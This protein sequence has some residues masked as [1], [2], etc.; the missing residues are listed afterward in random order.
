M[1]V[2][3]RRHTH[4]SICLY[5]RVIL[6]V[7][8]RAGPGNVRGLDPEPAPVAVA[9]AYRGCVCTMPALPQHLDNES[10]WV[11]HDCNVLFGHDP[12]TPWAFSGPRL[13]PCPNCYS[14]GQVF[15]WDQQQDSHHSPTPFTEDSPVPRRLPRLP[16]W[17]PR[18]CRR[19]HH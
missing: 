8:W 14:R 18:C 7:P 2:C 3:T 15:L 12:A 19:R 17:Q 13:V 10:W 6:I 11:C 16:W 5:V 4:V 1:C 9:I